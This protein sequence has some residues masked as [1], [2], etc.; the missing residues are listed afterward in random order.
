MGL[1]APSTPTVDRDLHGPLAAGGSAGAGAGLVPAPPRWLAQPVRHV[2]SGPSQQC[3]EQSWTS[4]Q[5]SLDQPGRRRI[6]GLEGHLRV[7]TRMGLRPLEHS[8]EDQQVAGAVVIGEVDVEPHPNQ[9]PT[10][11]RE[12]VEVLK[13]HSRVE[14][15]VEPSQVP[16]VNSVLNRPHRSSLRWPLR[17]STA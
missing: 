14:S 17:S 15:R 9:L 2:T 4:L 6:V 1:Q 12:R 8:L 7:V 11:V 16:D 13:E 3:G 5:V 10:F